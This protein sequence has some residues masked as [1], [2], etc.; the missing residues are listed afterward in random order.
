MSNDQRFEKL[1]DK[2]YSSMEARIDRV[3]LYFRN[4]RP[5]GAKK[6][7]EEKQ[8]QDFLQ[9]RDSPEAWSAI[10]QQRGMKNA[11]KYNEFGERLVNKWQKKA[12]TGL[13]MDT[14]EVGPP[15]K[16]NPSL[17]QALMQVFDQTAQQQQQP[18][19]PQQPAQP[20][21]PQQP[22]EQQQAAP[23]PGNPDGTY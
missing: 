9:V 23:P 14:A 1:V 17:V 21:Q 10:I 18:Q 20:Q 22:M 6:A 15:R 4:E 7:P 3:S 5:P 19:Q 16:S 13:G 11:I 12:L 8:V 2:L